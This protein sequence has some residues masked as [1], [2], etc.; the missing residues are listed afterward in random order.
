MTGLRT[1]A[2]IWFPRATDDGKRFLLSDLFPLDAI[3]FQKRSETFLNGG[4]FDA[5]G[6][7]HCGGSHPTT[8]GQF[9]TAFGAAGFATAGFQIQFDGDRSAEFSQ[10]KS[11]VE[12][13]V[14]HLEIDAWCT[15]QL[16]ED[17]ALGTV[18]DEGS[19]IGDHRQ[20]AHVSSRLAQFVGLQV[21]Q[22]HIH[23]Q[24]T[25]MRHVGLASLLGRTGITGIN[26]IIFELPVSFAVGSDERKFK[27]RIEFAGNRRDFS[28]EGAQG[29]F[30]KTSV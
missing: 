8:F 18:D 29:F 16:S 27:A 19:T 3:L 10:D 1:A 25:G 21:T 24:A 28:E 6:G 13:R 4:Q 9:D 5:H 12:H 15:H 20:V 22:P 14:V 17:D 11:F 2:T 26:C 23:E 30:Q 7:Q